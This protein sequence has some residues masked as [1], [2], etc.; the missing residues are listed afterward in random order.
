MSLHADERRRF[1]GGLKTEVQGIRVLT[2]TLTTNYIT[3]TTTAAELNYGPQR[4]M[5]IVDGEGV[6]ITTESDRLKA[7]KAARMKARALRREAFQRRKEEMAAKRNEELLRK[8][9][10]P[11]IDLRFAPL[12]EKADGEGGLLDTMRATTEWFGKSIKNL[13]ALA[14]ASVGGDDTNEEGEEDEEKQGDVAKDHHEP[15]ENVTTP[16]SP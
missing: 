1:A 9:Q 4:R 12:P 13:A 7:K 15:A 2:T 5:V 14:A 11:Q 6:D 16:I 10:G 8:L 3:T